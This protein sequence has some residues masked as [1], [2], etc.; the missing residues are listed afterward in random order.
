MTQLNVMKKVFLALII[1]FIISFTYLFTQVS[2]S[3][4][5][6]ITDDQLVKENDQ[7]YLLLDNR[8]LKINE[9]NLKHLQMDKYKEY[10][11]IYSYNKLI[12]GKGKIERLEPYGARFP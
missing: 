3:V 2:V 4:T 6:E 9:G 5:K 10:K 11:I 8:N 7:Y 1:I 12:S